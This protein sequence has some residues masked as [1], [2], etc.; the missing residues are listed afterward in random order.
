MYNALLDFTASRHRP[1][2]GH[3]TEMEEWME[4]HGYDSVEE[5]KGRMN[6]KN[7]LTRQRSTRSIPS[8]LSSSW[9]TMPD[10]I[11]VEVG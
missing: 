10:L 4:A 5:L 11:E 8:G 6:Q 2:S 7:C 1:D 9:R 3:R